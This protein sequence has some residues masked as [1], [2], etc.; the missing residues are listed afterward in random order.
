MN[1]FNECI[2]RCD[3]AWMVGHFFALMGKVP[4]QITKYS[5]FK[6]TGGVCLFED[7]AFLLL[8]GQNCALIR[9]W[10]WQGFLVLNVDYATLTTLFFNHFSPHTKDTACME[11]TCDKHAD[12]P[13]CPTGNADSLRKKAYSESS[14]L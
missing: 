13:R 6:A 4:H 9:K 11:A 8:Q 2:V 1:F 5:L 14:V 3:L 7:G 10:V 12:W